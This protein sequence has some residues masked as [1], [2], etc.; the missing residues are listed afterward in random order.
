M[1]AAVWTKRNYR[2]YHRSETGRSWWIAAT[3]EEW[4]AAI[5]SGLSSPKPPA[6]WIEL[7]ALEGRSPKSAAIIWGR[8]Y[9]VSRK[10]AIWDQAPEEDFRAGGY[11]S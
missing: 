8:Q 3:R 5:L 1:V 7:Q 9:D 4:L 2:Y 11:M 6:S 10:Y